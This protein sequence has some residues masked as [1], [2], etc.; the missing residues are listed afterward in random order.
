MRF[1]D[2]FLRKLTER[3]E[4]IAMGRDPFFHQPAFRQTIGSFYGVLVDEATQKRLKESRNLE[5]VLLM[6]ISSTQTS[7]KKRI[8]NEAD[9]RQEIEIQFDLFIRVVHECLRA[10]PSASRELLEHLSAYKGNRLCPSDLSSGSSIP[11]IP[12]RRSV[13]AA[14]SSSSSLPSAFTSSTS[15][16]PAASKALLSDSDPAKSDLIVA[17][18]KL[19][20]V[21]EWQL[22]LDV[23]SV[24]QTCSLPDG[25]VDLKRCIY[26]IH[27]QTPWPGCPDDFLTPD[28]YRQWRSQELTQL[29]QLVAELC[30]ARPDLLTASS[31]SDSSS[32]RKASSDMG[33]LES[34]PA[35]SFSMAE[36]TKD[37]GGSD[38]QPDMFTYIPPD[39][40]AA[41]LR[42]LERCID[43]D[44]DAIRRKAADE[45]VSLT[46]LSPIHTQLLSTCAR[47]WR[48]SPAYEKLARLRVCRT[49]FD[50]GEIPFECLVD[51]MVQ[52]E[53]YID[54][55]L[56]V[57]MWRSADRIALAKW[58]QWL[59][60][61][62]LRV[63]Y[64]HMSKLDTSMT[65]E[66]ASS[67]RMIQ[68][69]QSLSPGEISVNTAPL[70]EAMRKAAMHA[71]AAEAQSVFRAHSDLLRGFLELHTWVERQIKAQSL[72]FSTPRILGFVPADQV[73]IGLVPMY[74]GDLASVHEAIVLQVRQSQDIARV[75]DALDLF[76]QIRALMRHCESDVRS[77]PSTSGTA[78]GMHLDFDVCA[79]FRAFVEMWIS[80]SEERASQWVH[81]AIQND[82]FEPVDAANAMHSS[83]V[84]DMLEALQQPIVY[85]QSL[86]WP[87]EFQ[88][89]EFLTS[90]SRAFARL[91]EQYCHEVAD[92]YMADMSQQQRELQAPAPAS[93]GPPSSPTTQSGAAQSSPD[94]SGKDEG[95]PSR[96]MGLT[97]PPKQAAWVA[98]AKQTLQSDFRERWGRGESHHVP[99]PPFVLQPHSCVML[100]NMEAARQLLDTLYQRIDADKQ[101]DIVQRH[102]RD[103]GSARLPP[104]QAPVAATTDPDESGASTSSNH[105][106]S[107]YL[108]SVKVVQAELP[109]SARASSR[110]DTFVT[111]SD[112]RGARLA[113]T[114]TI[115]DSCSPR[116]DEVVDLP[117]A[118]A[119]WISATMWHRLPQGDPLL[120]GRATVRLDPQLFADVN[121]H[122]VWLDLDRTGG[123]LLLR[124]SM[125]DSQDGILF[126]FGRAFRIVKR[127]E[128][129]MTRALVDHISLYMRRILS[130]PV[131]ASLVRGG[132]MDRALGNVRALYASALAQA[133]G[134]APGLPLLPQLHLP[135]SAPQRRPPPL[136]DQE[137]E[138]A[139]VPLLDYFEETL[140]TL[141]SSLTPTQAQL[142]LTRVWKEVLAT[143]ESLLVP[144]LSDAPSDMKQLSDKEVDIVFK[145][146]SF[147]R[148][149]FNAYDPETGVA[150]GL[151]LSILQGSKYRELLSYLLLHDQSTDALMIECVRGFQARLAASHSR[152][153]SVLQQRSLGTIRQ[154][155]RAKQGAGD[156][157]SLMSDMA[158]KILRMRPG[159]SDF[160]AQQL[161]SL[162][163]LQSP[164]CVKPAS[165]RRTQ[166]RLA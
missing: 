18:G 43:R 92:R 108:F 120:F 165:L 133:N 153:K 166:K 52:L 139:I 141:H 146:L 111:L 42:L 45:D 95:P 62:L 21:E 121:T 112:D 148:S 20:D 109:P 127:T 136:T 73:A 144:P 124:V 49:K 131:L 107:P 39:P 37:V 88:Q 157:T 30:Q 142:V 106:P 155:K 116:W 7:V 113:K 69:A 54:K 53:L 138:A 128:A 159:T 59:S 77:A 140:G 129:E 47:R 55:E 94:R 96:A 41:Y 57:S 103:A 31:T 115:F 90:L 61:S 82:S 65:D 68:R 156:D 36:L 22:Q 6:F 151:P 14:S 70:E 15:T 147:L 134:A 86:D 89:A 51:A 145:W 74:L 98:R 117:L 11:T 76:Q 33:R 13:D 81:G 12:S 4:R 26:Q 34:F 101:A 100:N 71:Y 35:S 83:S 122:D 19:F 75:N 44:L 2:K 93:H 137:I 149:Y 3:M 56:P 46:I 135:A 130:R 16:V 125:E 102:A 162:H 154:H 25:I 1:P 99:P 10:M 40:C 58:M 91:V 24:S 97:L 110:L 132:R 38:D 119:Q 105:V 78:G 164:A 104:S 79:F 84:Q 163:S 85:V 23:Q 150:H 60:D 8:V 158:M 5:S 17:T 114:R 66:C 27:A 123:K 64:S 87:N 50:A 118:S 67:I 80:F 63:V 161:I 32:R 28:A 72:R 48:V 126:I 29:S 160:L 9:A 152:S 143:L